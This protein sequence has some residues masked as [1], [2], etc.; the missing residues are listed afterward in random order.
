VVA[1]LGTLQAVGALTP[2]P[3][4]P[5]EAAGRILVLTDGDNTAGVTPLEAAAR[6]R[7]AKVPVYTILL[8]NDPQRRT[9]T[10]SPAEQMAQLATQTGGVFTQTRDAP[11]LRRV[12]E[13]LGA[14]FTTVSRVDELSIY[15]ALIMVALLAAAGAVLVLVRPYG[16]GSARGASA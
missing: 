9:Q 12:F 4:S 2:P 14:S 7:A 5:E 11:D 16:G 1:S 3:T 10:L 6:A 8:G 13:D 15:V